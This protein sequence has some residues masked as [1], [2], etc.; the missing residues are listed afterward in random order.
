MFTIISRIPR[1]IRE[2]LLAQRYRGDWANYACKHPLLSPGLTAG[3][4]WCAD[5]SAHFLG[6]VF[7]LVFTHIT[8]SVTPTFAKTSVCFTSFAKTSVC[9]NFIKVL[10]VFY[11]FALADRLVNILI[12]LTQ[13][14][15]NDFLT[16]FC[17]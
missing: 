16:C 2:G 7:R 11:V 10:F 14:N 12:I 9:F 8:R 6:S 15:I 13:N 5:Y 3:R 4:A 17:K 1:R